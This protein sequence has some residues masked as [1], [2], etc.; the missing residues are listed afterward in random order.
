[1]ITGC[2]PKMFNLPWVKIE[3]I[4]NGHV[5]GKTTSL[6]RNK[7]SVRFWLSW[8]KSCAYL[9]MTKDNARLCSIVVRE[10]GK[11]HIKWKVRSL[12]GTQYIYAWESDEEKR[13]E[14]HSSLC[15]A[16]AMNGRLLGFFGP[17]SIEV[18]L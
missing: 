7:K 9:R 13:E 6:F 18:I 16:E 2:I 14:L 17:H 4:E 12:L 3:K 11:P 15:V 1:M 8:R 10:I 5:S